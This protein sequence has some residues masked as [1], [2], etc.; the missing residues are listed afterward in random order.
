MTVIVFMFAAFRCTCFASFY[1][2]F[3]NF[4]D[5]VT[6]TRHGLSSEA[7]DFGTFAVQSD[8]VTKHR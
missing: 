1:A 4:S 5:E 6:A 3:A 8:T 7:T 2:K